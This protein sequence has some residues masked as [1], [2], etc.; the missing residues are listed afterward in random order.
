MGNRVLVSLDAAI[1]VIV[2]ALWAPGLVAQVPSGPADLA[3]A[4][5]ARTWDPT[6]PAP[7]GWIPPRTAWGD[8]DL[9][10]YWLNF[11]YTPV[12]R[13]RQLAD[14]PLYTVAEAV[15]A[16]KQAV[17]LDAE[18]DP[19]TVHYD[20]NEYGMKAWQTPARPN[21][22][23]A[24]IVDPPDGRIPPLTAEAQ[25]RQAAAAAEAARDPDVSSYP[26]LFTRCIIGY[27]GWPRA[28]VNYQG[29]TQFVQ[30]PGYVLQIAQ[31]NQDV[32]IIPLDGRPHLPQ[33]IRTW[34]GDARGHFEGSTLVVESTNFNDKRNWRGSTT[35]L[36]L[37]ERYTRVDPNILRYEFT[38][39]DPTTWTRSWTVE[40]PM[41]RIQAP[42]YEGECHET[43]YG[44]INVIKGL[45]LRQKEG[46]GPKG[47]AEVY[48]DEDGK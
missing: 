10:G 30:T 9:Q 35:G 45:Q 7:S 40:N 36:H 32:R 19:T 6:A 46:I 47:R 16:F 3:A 39:D 44:I 48:K 23:T 26:A 43:N 17:S 1:L 8:P 27:N 28:P 25:K 20:F 24:L 15:E 4:L 31:A 2:V 12:E 38:V 11:T 18:V 41:P 5:V 33:D 13:P 21:R 14:K 29:E 42:I 34:S 22:R 37:I